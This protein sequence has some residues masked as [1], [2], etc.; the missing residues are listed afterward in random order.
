MG[1]DRVPAV[2]VRVGVEVAADRSVRVSAAALESQGDATQRFGWPEERVG[3]GAMADLFASYG[4]LLVR[5]AQ[6][7]MSDALYYLVIQRC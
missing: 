2:V 1:F 3:V 6:G 5:E 4:I 7:R